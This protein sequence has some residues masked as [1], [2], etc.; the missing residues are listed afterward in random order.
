M[1]NQDLLSIIVLNYNRLELTKQT[2]ERL[3]E[4]TTVRHNFIFV[5]NGSQDGTREY[6]KSIKHSTNAESVNYVFN[7]SN[8]GVA[9]GRNSGLKI[10]TGD[11]LMT[12]DDD[13]LVPEHYDKHLIEV[14]DNIKDIG[15]TGICVEKIKRT[16]IQ[17]IDGIDVRVKSGNLGGACLCMPRKTFNKVGYFRPDFIYGIEDVDLHIRL[18]VLKLRSVYILPLGK[19]IDKRKNKVYEKLKKSV[20]NKRSRVF[21]KIGEN[22]IAYKK[23]KNVYVPYIIPK[24][25]SRKF[26]KAIKNGIKK[27][28]K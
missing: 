6:L 4:T 22:E 5:D 2:I 13:I 23:T 3:I 20:Y 18:S 16:S 24:T 12:I 17:S 1:K 15:I 21:A 14:C 10:A 19:H 11:Y 25:S 8:Y 26:D 9:G 27:K 7:P 28:P